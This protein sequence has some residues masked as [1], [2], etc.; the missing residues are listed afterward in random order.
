MGDEQ[1]LYWAL[2]LQ[3]NFSKTTFSLEAATAALGSQQP[4]TVAAAAAL[5]AH[6]A[7]AFR[8]AAA[9]VAAQLSV[10]ISLLKK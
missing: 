2:D 10:H 1:M 7:A 9:A 4:A 6:A 5:A 3:H 8:A